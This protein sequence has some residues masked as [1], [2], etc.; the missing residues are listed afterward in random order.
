MKKVAI[1]LLDIYNYL[2][3][4]VATVFNNYADAGQEYKIDFRT[5]KLPSGV[6]YGILQS[7]NKQITRKL[8][9]IK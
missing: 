5:D 3:S 2:G 7:S 9:I 1:T 8:L 4:K 6:Y